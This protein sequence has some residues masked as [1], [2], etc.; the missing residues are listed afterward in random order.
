MKRIITGLGIIQDSFL[1]WQAIFL[2]MLL[3]TYAP[4][5]FPFLFWALGLGYFLVQIDLIFDAFLFYKTA[6]R[7]DVS[8]FA[9]LSDIRSFWDSAKARGVWIFLI[10][11]A[12]MLVIN[13]TTI[14]Y[15]QNHMAVFILSSPFLWTGLALAVV[16]VGA[17]AFLPRRIAYSTSNTLLMQQIWLLCKGFSVLFST[18]RFSKDFL[19]P[20]KQLFFNDEEDF[21]L[22]TPEYPI[23]KYTHG[24]TGVKTCHIRIEAA[25]QPH[26]I[27]LF[28]E[29]W[30]ASDI[31]IL[32]GAY[33]IT[34]NFDRLA[35]EGICFKNFYSNSV[36]TSRAVTASQF[37]IPSDVETFD[38][39]SVPRF[40]LIS[41]A[42]VLKRSG[43]MC[44]YFIGNHLSFENQLE[45][46]SSHGYDNLAGTEEI[47]KAIPGA[48]GTSWGVH[49]Q[50]LMDYTIDHLDKNRQTPQFCT[51]FTISN[52]HPWID[53]PGPHR[54]LPLPAF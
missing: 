22:L 12:A 2:V 42:H 13:L 8:F 54:R 7:F 11:G 37:G 50:Y 3:N 47:I 29:S 4:F 34:P 15:L 1:A 49:D 10:I 14:A 28:M 38:A 33:S 51:L 30:R 20:N 46:L 17:H 24:F 52:H 39:S 19:M 25:E 43:Y 18:L 9:F 35:H 48:H 32:G 26:V 23:L 31:G 44:N 16:S 45:C 5:A 21:T 27:F 53:P 6:M 41:I 40:P 36:K